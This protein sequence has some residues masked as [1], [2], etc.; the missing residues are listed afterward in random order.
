MRFLIR[1]ALIAPFLTALVGCTEVGAKT[2]TTSIKRVSGMTEAN[3]P[4]D[5]KGDFWVE[6]PN[7]SE[8]NAPTRRNIGHIYLN[9]LPD[10]GF[11]LIGGQP[12][13]KGEF[14]ATVYASSGGGRCT[15]NVIGPQAVVIA[16]HC[17]GDGKQVGFVIEGVNYSSICKHAPDYNR[18]ETADWALCKVTKV[19]EGIKYESLNTDEALLKTGQKITLTGYGCVQPGGG[20]GNDGTL[21]V[22]EAPIIKMPSGTN[23][24]IV[25]QGEVALCFG[26]SG[27]PAYW[28]DAERKVRYQVSINSRGDIR[29]TSYLSS[30][31]NG[32]F[33][34]FADSW[35]SQN[36]VEVCGLSAG[37]KNC[38]NE[39]KPEP[40]PGELPEWCGTALSKLQACLYGK[41]RQALS[42]PQ[43]CRDSYATLFAC[44]EAAEIPAN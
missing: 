38:R 22:G 34:A 30:T 15:A 37:A 11:N 9:P 40:E 35:M 12:A 20:G 14:P 6:V 39:V 29:K 16:A 31:A 10:V 3:I 41:P 17:V 33:K 2:N 27:G 7:D 18:N 24:D 36:A 42:D 19:V 21:R 32:A 43:G 5:Y 28:Y 44:E 8:P 4:E 23:Y 25:T 1:L 26:D 13:L